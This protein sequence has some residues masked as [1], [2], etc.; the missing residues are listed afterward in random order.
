[1]RRARRDGAFT[2]FEVMAAVLVLGMLYAVLAN[3]A[4]QGLY[5]EGETRRRLEASLLADRALA[6]LELQLSLGQIPPSGSA[7]QAEDPYLVSVSVQ[8][9]DPTVLR[10]PPEPG[11]AQPQASAQPAESLLLPPSSGNEG[12]LRRIDVLVTW[13]EAGQERSIGRTTFAF[14]TSGLEELFPKEGEGAGAGT[15]GK[16]REAA[17][18]LENVAPEEAFDRLQNLVNPG[19]QKK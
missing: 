14:D 15:D 11:E 8:P 4:M 13:P 7:E 9:F 17:E 1:M 19:S 2:L 18:E 6:E 3:A 12:R 16:G 10:V 5:S